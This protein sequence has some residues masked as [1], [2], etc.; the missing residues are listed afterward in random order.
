MPLPLVLFPSFKDPPFA[1]ALLGSLTGAG[2]AE[3]AFGGQ[4]EGGVRKLPVLG[5]GDGFVQGGKRLQ[6]L[7]C[8]VGL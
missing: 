8:L 1:S 2:T 5:R 3:V 7:N 4:I 6:L